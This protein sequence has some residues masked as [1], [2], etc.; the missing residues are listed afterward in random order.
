MLKST[1]SAL[2]VEA[3]ITAITAIAPIATKFRIRFSP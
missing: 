1:S 3:E 2:A